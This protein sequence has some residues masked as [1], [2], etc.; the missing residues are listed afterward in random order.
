MLDAEGLIPYLYTY[1]A[2]LASQQLVALG[3]AAVEPLIAVLNGTRPVPDLAPLEAT[4][5]SR[6]LLGCLNVP[7]TPATNA[8]R[9][10]AA[11]LLGDIGDM[12]AVEPLIA[13]L[14]GANDRFMRMAIARSLGKIGDVRAVEPLI[15]VLAAPAWTPDFGIL[16]DDLAR[17]GGERAVEP[18]LGVLLSKSYSYGCAARAARILADRR[19]D[20]RVIDGLIGALRLDAEFT[21]L[22]AVI[23][24]LG[25]WG[26]VRG[27]AALLGFVNAL[28]ALPAEQWDDR[29]EN[30]SETEQGVTFH[31]LKTEFSAALAALRRIDDRESLDALERALS[32]AAVYIPRR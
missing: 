4:D 26:A 25:E 7:P 1:N 27:A 32:E 21:T 31:I 14:D 29:D 13:A 8:A 6:A 12:R 20:P 3:G 9:E 11:Y 15:T 2:R 16:V 19:D 5:E 18:L 24:I 22:Q 10:R 30:L 28:M 17:I 23:E